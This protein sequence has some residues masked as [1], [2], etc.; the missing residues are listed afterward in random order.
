MKQSP[1]QD[2]ESSSVTNP[3]RKRSN[4]EDCYLSLPAQALW[5]VADGM[6]GHEAGEVAEARLHRLVA[7]HGAPQLRPLVLLGDE[8]AVH[9]PPHD[10]RR[11]FSH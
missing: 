9:E 2:L 5:M 3:G 1:T 8:A 6:G 7:G 4:N 11:T 10:A